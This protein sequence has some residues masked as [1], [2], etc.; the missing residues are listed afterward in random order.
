MCINILFHDF[1]MNL[2]PLTFKIYINNLL[3]SGEGKKGSGA[4]GILQVE[5][6]DV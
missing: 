3:P 1:E 5:S 6:R 4:G 2:Y